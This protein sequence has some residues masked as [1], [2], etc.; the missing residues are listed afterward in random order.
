MSK[1]LFRRSNKQG[2]HPWTSR[3][4]V[5]CKELIGRGTKYLDDDNHYLCREHAIERGI[6][7]FHPTSEQGIIPIKSIIEK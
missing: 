5:C 6:R 3:C 2:W 1:P 7:V 4:Y